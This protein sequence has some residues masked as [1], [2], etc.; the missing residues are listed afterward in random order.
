MSNIVPTG[1]LINLWCI[2]RENR[3]IFKITIGLGNDLDDLK[4]VIKEGKPNYFVNADADELIL[5]RTNVAS[6]ILRNKET[7]IESYL[8]EKLEDPADTVRNTFQNVVGNNIRV[9]VDVPVTEQPSARKKPRENNIITTD[10]PLQP[11][12]GSL[13]ISRNFFQEV[14]SILLNGQSF[15]IHGPYQSGKSTFLFH[16]RTSFIGKSLDFAHLTM[17]GVK[18]SILTNVRTGFYD[19]MSFMLF[20]ET[21][22]ET[23]TFAHIYN[24]KD[25]LYILID[26]FQYIFTNPELCE[27]AKDFFREISNAMNIHYVAVGTFKLVDLKKSDSD[28]LISPFNKAL[29]KQMP[30]FSIQEMGEL[31]NLYQS[32]LDKNGVLLDLRTKIIEESCGHPASFMILLKLFY[33]FRPTLDKWTRVLQGNLERYMNVTHTKLKDEIEEMDDNE[34]EYLRELTDYQ[35]DHWSMEL[36]DLTK[37]DDIDNKLLD[38]GILYIMDINK[39]GFTSCI[40][41]RVCIN[42]TFPTSSKRLSRDEVP[43]DPVDLLEL[44]LKLIDPRTITDKRAKNKHGPR[45]RAMQASL[46]S[47]FNGLLPKPEMMCLMELKSGGSYLMITDGDQNLTAY[48]LKCGVTSE[49]KFKEAFE[50]AWVYSDYF[51]MEICIVNFL[52]NSHDD[53]NIPYDTHDI[54]LISVEHNDECTRFVIQSQTHDYQERIVT[55]YDCGMFHK[56]N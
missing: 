4:K 22:D 23:K 2:V 15:V 1:T 49:K 46:F 53:L 42:A 26:E 38:I 5:W 52:P 10:G 6:N 12:S 29:F 17:A 39:V 41:L 14:E 25:P 8:N 44:G 19:Y 31:F 18:G 48:S 9:I 37:L 36:G 43:S 32:N 11:L 50:H 3:S 51:H 33:D 55:I 28:K 45:E 35:K 24:L 7:A 16:L 20:K 21:L 54:V 34:K 13:M 47:I 56:N 27:V 40:I 30:M